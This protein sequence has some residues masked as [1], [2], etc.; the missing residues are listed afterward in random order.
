MTIRIFKLLA[1]GLFLHCGL[2]LSSS[3]DAK[4]WDSY[5]LSSPHQ[6][7]QKLETL[8]LVGKPVTDK[9]FDLLFEAGKDIFSQTAVLEYWGGSRADTEESTQK[10]KNFLNRCKNRTENNLLS[11]RG[12]YLNEP[13][14]KF[15]GF[16]GANR[17]QDSGHPFDG[18][19]EIAY[20]FDSSSWGKGYATE[21]L[22]CLITSDIGRLENYKYI[23]ATVHPENHP[24][25]KLAKKIGLKEWAL[26]QSSPELPDYL[27]RENRRFYKMEKK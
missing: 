20:A 5:R 17:Y 19:I 8:R 16:V 7:V 22:N 11:W 2:V 18:A 14:D 15:V 27:K 23:F 25:I 9:T 6:S 1:L 12:F 3:F 10:W 21:A 26:D 13:S 24:S 4:E